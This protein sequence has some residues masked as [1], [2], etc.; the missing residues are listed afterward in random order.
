MIPGAFEYAA[1]KS[2]P[3]AIALLQQHGEDA[4]ILAGGHSLIPLMKLRL[5]Q[6]AYLIDIN[7]IPGLDYI[8]EQDG[9]LRIGALTRESSIDASQL[10]Q[11]RYPLL[12]DTARVIADPLVRNLATVGGNIAHADPANDHPATMLAYNASV[13]VVGPR[14]ERVI[15][16]TNFFIDLFLT[17]LGQDEILTEIRIP[18]PPARSGGAYIKLERKVGDYATAAVAAQI[19]LDEAGVCQY[20]GIGLTAVSSVPLKA[21][22][23]EDAL[24]GQPLT[25]EAIRHAAQLASEDCDPTADLRGSVE[26]KRAMVK[27]LTRRALTKARE[28]ANS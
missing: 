22:R 8:K 7:K 24:R 26:Y 19:T 20:V 23:S 16:I 28:R 14:G 3:E 17:D 12:A 25:D 4:K 10:V 18:T 15:P 6:P 11:T 5:A 13:V 21:T 9:E 2:L 1:P 27:E